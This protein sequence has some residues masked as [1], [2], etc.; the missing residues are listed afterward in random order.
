MM[1]PV[2]EKSVSARL[3]AFLDPV[4]RHGAIDIYPVGTSAV[5]SALEAYGSVAQAQTAREQP[6]NA[7]A[8]A[9]ATDHRSLRRRRDPRAHCVRRCGD[10][11]P[12]RSRRLGAAERHH[13]A[14]RQSDAISNP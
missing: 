5:T 10:A 14:N 7:K 9:I 4:D 8:D 11:G 1:E 13:S 3:S 12:G 2:A 6:Q